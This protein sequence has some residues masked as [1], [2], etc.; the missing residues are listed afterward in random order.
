MENV[1]REFLGRY[2]APDVAGVKREFARR[3]EIL[4]SLTHGIGA[5][6]GIVGLF[7][8]LMKVS[9]G[10]AIRVFSALFYGLSLIILYSASAIYHAVSA[11]YGKKTKSRAVELF[12]KCDHSMIFLLIL[13]TY[14]PVCLVGLGG[15]IGIGIFLFVFPLCALG[16][17]LNII[18]VR[19]FKRLSIFMNLLTGWTITVAFYPFYLAVGER[20]INYLVL[21]GILY[22][23]GVAFYKRPDVRNMHTVWHLCVLGGSIMHFILIYS[24]CL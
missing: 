9:G 12:M 3:E 5:I 1:K 10:G 11:A 21:G 4:N 16:I 22:T 19:R 14:T 8:L 24:Y 23:V 2:T 18:D 7:M 15:G 20:G 17:V 13:G 6:F